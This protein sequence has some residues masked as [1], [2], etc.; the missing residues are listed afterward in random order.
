MNSLYSLFFVIV[1]ILLPVLGVLVFDWTSLFGVA[2]L[3]VSFFVFIVGVV[4]RVYRVDPY[5]AMVERS[6]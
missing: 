1:L 3:Y 5:E 2:V 6:F 4:Y